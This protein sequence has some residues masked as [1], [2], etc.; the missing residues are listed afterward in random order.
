[1]ND[2]YGA[3]QSEV[4]K[5]NQAPSSEGLT[6][7][8]IKHLIKAKS[9]AK[10]LGIVMFIMLGLSIISTL[11]SLPSIFILSPG[12]GI[13]NLLLTIISAVLTFFLARYMWRY[14][15]AVERLS[16]EHNIEHVE[17]AQEQFGKFC[18]LIIIVLIVEV[19]F[20]VLMLVIGGIFMASSIN[21]FGV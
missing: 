18:R 4:M 17:N 13:I 21:G 10:F 19:I 11:I 20:M 7:T 5:T 15:K 9:W 3:P 16:G 12:F 6:E 8:M 14:G 1:M 2:I